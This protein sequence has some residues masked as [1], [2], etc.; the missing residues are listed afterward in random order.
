MAYCNS[1]L[2][3]T[4]I[5]WQRCPAKAQLCP[6]LSTALY[7]LQD[8]LTLISQQQGHRPSQDR[9]RSLLLPKVMPVWDSSPGILK[10]S[11]VPSAANLEFWMIQNRALQPQLQSPHLGTTGESHPSRCSTL[12]LQPD[13]PTG[14]RL[15]PSLAKISL[16]MRWEGELGSPGVSLFLG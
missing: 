15:H 13:Y 11:L 16:D 12:G 2:L 14:P 7:S 5:N 3:W 4:W 8:T 10:I 6:S 9:I 1:V